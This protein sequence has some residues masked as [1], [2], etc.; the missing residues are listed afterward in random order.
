MKCR[1]CG[2]SCT[3]ADAEDCDERCGDCA[4]KDN[5]E[6]DRGFHGPECEGC[7]TLHEDRQRIHDEQAGRAWAEGGAS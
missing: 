4:A 2:M 3:D 7:G 6:R 1:I 5:Y